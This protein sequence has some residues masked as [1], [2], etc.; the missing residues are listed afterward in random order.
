ML[1]DTLKNLGKR[2]GSEAVHDF[3]KEVIPTAGDPRAN[4]YKVIAMSSPNLPGFLADDCLK[5]P[6]H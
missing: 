4:G 2:G 1:E 6:H 5:V 3:W